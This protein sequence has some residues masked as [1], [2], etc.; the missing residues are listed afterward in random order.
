MIPST[1][2]PDFHNFLSNPLT[3]L[4]E[5][6][7]RENR[8]CDISLVYLF[9]PGLLEQSSFCVC[10]LCVGFV[11]HFLGVFTLIIQNWSSLAFTIAESHKIAGGILS[12]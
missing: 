10:C 3:S 1:Q 9:C 5:T 8:P 7:K 4:T 12:C 2:N 6:Q 11:D